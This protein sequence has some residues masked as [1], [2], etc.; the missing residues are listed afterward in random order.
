MKSAAGIEGKEGARL[1]HGGWIEPAFQR[2]SAVQATLRA[3]HPFHDAHGVI[4]RR[5]SISRWSRIRF[6]QTAETQSA[7]SAGN[8]AAAVPR[9]SPSA[10]ARFPLAGSGSERQLPS[11]ETVRLR[12]SST[13]LP[14]CSRIRS[15]SRKKSARFLRRPGSCGEVHG[16]SAS[17]AKWVSRKVLPTRR[18]PQTTASCGTPD[19]AC[20]QARSRSRVHSHDR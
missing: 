9:R 13:A 10:V 7:K 11:R 17:S 8:S 16:P 1:A 4:A 19:R 20:C 12:R 15:V 3:E 14:S 2:G 6:S 5:T 18:R